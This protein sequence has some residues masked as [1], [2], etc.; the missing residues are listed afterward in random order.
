M[1]SIGGIVRGASS[2]WINGFVDDISLWKKV[3]TEEEIMALAEV[4]GLS[5]RLDLPIP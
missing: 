3:F 2:Y 5:S 4:L 1:T